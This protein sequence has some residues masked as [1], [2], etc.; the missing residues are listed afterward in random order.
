MLKKSMFI[1]IPF[2]LILIYL[3]PLW[4]LR[5]I[6]TDFPEVQFP[7]NLERN[8]LVILAHD[9][10]ACAVTGL[11]DKLTSEGWK[12]DFATFYLDENDGYRP[13]EIPVRKKELETFS[14]R[15][16]ISALYMPTFKMRKGNLDTIPEL[17]MPVAYSEMPHAFEVDSLEAIISNYIEKSRP[18]IIVSLDDQ[19]G[20]Y[21]HPEHVLVSRIIT[22]ICTEKSND[23]GFPVKHYYQSV[24]SDHQEK[25]L[26]QFPVYNK[27][28]EV[29]GINGMPSPTAQLSLENR[30]EAKHFGLSVWKSQ[31]R[32]IRKFFP[33]FQFYP[34]WIYFRVVNKEYY[35][36]LDF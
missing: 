6:E 13:R 15:F 12:L 11:I 20:G 14:T 27:A 18:S 23:A 33:Y 29:Y 32:N 22:K 35:R 9:D 24:F 3:A 4:N 5:L 36:V 1:V 10:D 31:Q 26:A 2:A 34:H 30:T 25:P 17:Y 19:M 28:K 21:G 16:G 7:E 8:A